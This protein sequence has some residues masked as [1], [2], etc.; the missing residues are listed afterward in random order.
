MARAARTLAATLGLLA[1]AAAAPGAALAQAAQTLP[2]MKFVTAPLVSPTTAVTHYGSATTHTNSL[3][4]LAG[5]N[6]TAPEI[7]ETARALK[8][9][10]DLIYEFVS[11]QIQTEYA[12]GERKG[13]VGTL[14]DKSGTPFDQN[15]LF[16]KL[17]RQAGY[18][19]HYQIGQVTMTSAAFAGWTG[20]TD[21]GAAC[22][23]LSSGGIPAV[24]TPSAPANCATSGAFTSVTILHIWSQVKI[25]SA[26][27][28]Y[29]PSFKTYA[30]NVT[31]VNLITASGLTAGGASG[32]AATGLG[33]GSQG[34]ANYIKNASQS[35]LN[36]YLNGLGGQLLSYFKTNQL[37]ANMPA[38]DIDQ[39][40]GLT[41]IQP[42]YEPPG[43]WR[44]P[45]PPGYTTGTSITITGDIPDQYRTSFQV[46]MAAALNEINF[47]TIL[48]HTF[49][50]DDIDG[51]R[52]GIATN[53]NTT[54]SATGGDIN[55]AIQYV[56][57]VP[58]PD[59]YTFATESIS[60]DDV[61]VVSST[62]T[63]DNNTC[64]G[65]GVPGQLTLTA[66]HP[67]AAGTFADETVVKNLSIIAAPVAIVSGWGM[68]SPARLTKWSD[69]VDKDTVLP[70]GGT[71]PYQ[72]E[73]GTGWCRAMYL[74]PAGD[75]TR[76]KL[77]A[78]WLAEMTRMLRLQ[79]LVGG[80]SVEHQHSIGVVD[81]RA[82]LQGSEW[83]P[84]PQGQINPIW[85][86]VYDEFTDLNI[87][88]VVSV[89]S[90][91][92]AASNSAVKTAAVSRSVALA[93]AALEGSVL[94]QMEDLPDTA[95]T[96]SRFAWSNDPGADNVGTD[97]EDP[98]FPTTNNPRPFFDFTGTS[99]ATRAGLYLYEGTNYTT[100][101]VTNLAACST[102]P[103]MNAQTSLPPL[104][105]AA[106]ETWIANYL[107]AGFKVTAS[108]EVF[109]GPGSRFGP[110]HVPISG[111]TPYNDLSAQR[112]GAIVATQFDGSGDVLQVAHVLTDHSGISKG[113]G[114]K[115]PE[116][117][118]EYDPNKAGD[119][120]KD[121]F[122]D[123]SVAL[124][125]DLKSGTA[126][127][128]TPSLMSVGVGAAP[129][130]LDYSLNYK[131]APSGCNSFG[132]CTSPI[133]GG[134]NQNWDVRFTNSGSGL[135][136][137]GATSPLAAA[138]T[139]VAFLA[140]Q[141]IFAQTTLANLNQDVFAALTADWWRQQM[142]ANVATINR[143]FSGAQYI[144]LVDG[145]W[146]PP[147]GMPGVLTQTGTRVKTRDM[148][149]SQDSG[150]YPYSTSR[151]WDQTNVTFSLRNAGGDVLGFAPWAWQYEIANGN[152]CATQYGY[153]PTTW[154]WPQGVSLTFT[155]G[156]QSGGQTVDYQPG[157]TAIASSLGRTMNFLGGVNGGTPNPL[158][159][160]AAGVSGTITVGQ[161]GGSATGP[162][163]DAANDPWNFIFT[164]PVAR[165]ATQRPVPYAQLQQVFEPV[166]ATLPALQYTYD[167]RG[168]VETAT[169][170]N[171]LQMTTNLPP[172][173]WYLALGG[174]GERDD[175]DGGAY[176]VYYDTDGDAVRNI[177]EIGR[178]V[179][180]AWDGR[181][182]VISRT[183]PES[184]Q[185][186]FGYDA[187]DNTLTLTRVPKTSSGLA[188]IVV[189]ATYETSWNH[190]ASITDP[191]SHTTNFFYNA[192]G[193]GTSLMN[194]A[195]RPSV[196][197]GR[198][199]YTFQYNAIGLPTQSVD[200]TG[201]T[202]T[203]VYNSYGDLTST[204]EAAAAVGAN[205]ALNLTTTFTPDAV[206]NVTAVQTPLGHLSYAVFDAARRQTFAIDPDPGTGTRTATRNTYDANGRV[207]QV[208]KGTTTSTT[209]SP[210]SAL[211]RTVTSFDPNGN[212]TKVSVYNG[213]TNSV[214]NPALILT[215]T[216]YDPLNRP[217]CTARRL[218]PSTFA[219]LPGACGQSPGGAN[220]YDLISQL[221][222]DLAGQ[223]LTEQRGVGTPGAIVYGTYTYS[224]DGNLLTQLDANN[225]LTTNAYDG[226]NRL[227]SVEFPLPTL[228]SG[229]SNPSDM[230]SYTYDASSNRKSVT[231]RDG[232]VISFD[233]DA[234]NRMTYKLFKVSLEAAD[235]VYAWD[236]AGRPA[237]ALFY[238]VTGTPGVTWAYDAAGRR[239]GEATSGFAG[240]GALAMSFA[241]DNDSNPATTTWPDGGSV[242]WAYDPA[243]RF[244]SVGN[245]A[246]SV[247]AG[248][249]TLS[250]VNAITRGSSVSTSALGYDRAD[251]PSSLAHV[252][253]PTTGNE[254]WGFT[255]TPASQLQSQTS[256]N[257]AWN[258]TPAATPAV[259]TTPDGL[260]RNAAVGGVTQ[261]YDAN[262]NLTGDG[263]RAF[264]YDV[265]N[266]LLTESGPAAMALSYDPTGRLQQSVING[267]TTQFLYDGADLVA[268]YD[269]SGTLKRR[270]VHGPD[271]DDPLIWFE[272]SAMTSADANYLIA[273][274]QG[275]IAA[276]A[277]AAGALSVNYTYDP[278]GVPNTWGTV[279]DRPPLPL[280]RPD[281]HP[282]GPALL[283]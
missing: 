111:G 73:G 134:W 116:S 265:E 154:T 141:D 197:G 226:F 208:D 158:T 230:E 205:P 254:S 219:S 87:D 114:G 6:A 175:P 234:I 20:V 29:D 110:A 68:I 47:T 201:V 227:S 185:E 178:E 184:D 80:Q 130:K 21:L 152:S 53:F 123:R 137:M 253:T 12:F 250:R 237:S 30:T 17:V 170:A 39:V 61:P 164:A 16:V 86:G 127:Y 101:P 133:Q 202:T 248:Y 142:V 63:I 188:N 103:Y 281:R 242:T 38:W 262:G 251:R 189:T 241:Y 95:S 74:Q 272:G 238:Q 89:G 10:P 135:E 181:H 280:H 220:G 115:Q 214:S 191:L 172:Y 218:T 88:S 264:T 168:L 212:K 50:V 97:L 240:A 169:D 261:T 132:P 1:L 129:Y 91:N 176:T 102:K 146:M 252:F 155:Y 71:I 120:L 211:E 106:N 161:T 26:Y 122:V 66:T 56:G 77:A 204:T 269:G 15:V 276:T 151:R 104:F 256:T 260:N 46:S 258:W 235:V 62:C 59:N 27:Y 247:A 124:G 55:P 279:G 76:Q 174:R 245:S 193:L 179:D 171:G 195:E 233:Y 143:G 109:L 166:S 243:D 150:E 215:Q 54:G 67:Y 267:V 24:F 90:L 3:A 41:K 216:S 231:K 14:I 8:N 277:G 145:S 157:V 49:F 232:L 177:D 28:A 140:M 75:F 81:W 275:T 85:L 225:N 84:P 228:G 136:A 186:Q 255:L 239:I 125:V 273:D 51:R 58:Q 203:H 249:D 147:V 78:S 131:A 153:Q 7:V 32:A 156:T 282:R 257:S 221:G 180:S 60:V 2:A 98:C 236:L 200:P 144:R 194:K 94:E 25:G 149:Q 52:I 99:S 199:T 79:G 268:E 107:A 23:M 207:I 96:A 148:C 112:G 182:R 119:A 183:F 139:L 5:F 163:T 69:E 283:L 42:V 19:A 57:G 45:T 266:R 100:N 83:P 108:S 271:V 128:N 43:G 187:L 196:T 244:S 190:L 160:S 9:N 173:S 210:F 118:T 22:R 278:Y 209:G 92:P 223:K 40:V 72:C 18:T 11:N 246:A 159:A 213:T 31:P 34:G 37:Q 167:T 192:S 229:A 33:S 13:A 138:G 165:S 35:Q 274:R 117:F 222:Y 4:G 48:N 64:F 126:G 105:I 259:A 82:Q 70:H 44:N 113:G 65:G 217:I 198:P 224:G 263:T 206:G 121:R 36:S 162:I 93:S 270:Y